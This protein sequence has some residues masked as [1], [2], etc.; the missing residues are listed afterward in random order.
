VAAEKY[1]IPAL[2]Y[3]VCSNMDRMIGASFD[4]GYSSDV[5]VFLQ[6]LRIIVHGSHHQTYARRLMVHACVMNLRKLQE[7]TAFRLLL[8]E[9]G[10][11]GA[12]IIGHR[13][14]ECGVLGSWFCST[15]CND[16]GR[17]VC[18]ECGTPFDVEHAWAERHEEWWVCS[19]C[20]D[21]RQPVCATCVR[22]IGWI[23]RDITGQNAE[24]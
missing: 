4:R 14:L 9:Y 15:G 19:H 1:Q 8:Q 13:D 23:E 10:R 18:L 12:D 21:E 22:R 16:N 7:K 6:A 11:L 2:Q 3:E 17:P 24:Q 5:D 20:L